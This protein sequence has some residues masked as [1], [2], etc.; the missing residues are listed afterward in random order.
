MP[1]ISRRR[2]V[3]GEGERRERHAVRGRRRP[4]GVRADHVEDQGPGAA[5]DD[6]RRLLDC[7]QIVV[8]TFAPRA[9]FGEA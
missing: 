8:G 3:T 4:G 6:Q 5:V 9:P 2:A 1:S 7:F